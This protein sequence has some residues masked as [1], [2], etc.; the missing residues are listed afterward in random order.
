MDTKGGNV[1]LQLALS[2]FKWIVGS[3]PANLK[4]KI[5]IFAFFGREYVR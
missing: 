1:S 5:R 2:I 3:G 4:T